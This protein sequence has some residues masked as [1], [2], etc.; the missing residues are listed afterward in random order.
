[1]NF[2]PRTLTVGLAAFTVTG[3]VASLVVVARPAHTASR[4]ARSAG[5]ASGVAEIAAGHRGDRRRP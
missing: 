5:P 2:G 3:A 4:S 1:M